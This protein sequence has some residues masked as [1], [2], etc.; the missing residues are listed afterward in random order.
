MLAPSEYE[1]TPTRGYLDTATY[2]LPPRSTLAAVEE[3]LASWR[4]R[5]SWLG[6]EQEKHERLLAL[7]DKPRLTETPA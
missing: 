6:W 5:G 7:T 2:G 4:E 1:G 3:A